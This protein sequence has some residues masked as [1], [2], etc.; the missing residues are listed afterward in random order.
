MLLA[1]QPGFYALQPIKRQLVERLGPDAAGSIYLQATGRQDSH[2]VVPVRLES[3]HDLARRNLQDYRQL[4]AAKKVALAA[5][6]VLNEPEVPP[7]QG[8]SRTMFFGIVRGATVS[9]KS[10]Y[11]LTGDVAG[12]DFQNDELQECPINFDVDPAILQ[13]GDQ[14]LAVKPTGQVAQRKFECVLSLLGIHSFAFGHWLMEFLPKVWMCMEQPGFERV[15]ILIDRQMPPQHREALRCFVGPEQSIETVAPN[16]TVHVDRL[17]VCPAP[18]YQPAGPK[19]G[20]AAAP[21]LLAADSSFMVPLLNRA[22]S[23]LRGIGSRQNGKRIFLVRK[24]SQ[25]RKLVNQPEV[26]EFLARQGFFSVDFGELSFGEQLSLIRSAKIVIA[27]DG[28]S[29]IMTMFAAKGARI[30]ILTHQYLEDYEWYAQL[31]RDL[32][33]FLCVLK[34][35]VIR[36][37]KSY[38]TFSDYRIDLPRLDQLLGWL[39]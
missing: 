25:H 10:N 6:R 14:L 8:A 15:T 20:A 11:I 35:E 12:L 2:H 29:S 13:H 23:R 37:D 28:S 27:A 34:G 39:E 24:A 36:E 17:W 18:Y 5:P 22:T 1:D 7:L 38:R 9:S 30:G 21:G 31:S 32:G 16:E 4:W 26:I 19:P 3:L 33:Q